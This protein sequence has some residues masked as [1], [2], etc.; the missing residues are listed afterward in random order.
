[1]KVLAIGAHPDDVELGCFATLAKLAKE[2]HEIHILVCT[3]GEAG[4]VDAEAK[5]SRIEEARQSAELLNAKIYFGNLPDTKLSDG[6][7]TIKLIEKYVK[8]INPEIL[9]F[10]HRNDIHQDHRHLASAVVSATRFTPHEV[11]M[12]ESPSTSKSFIPSVYF[13]V[14]DTFDIKIMAVKIHQSQGKKSYMADRAIRGLAE[15]RAFEIG[16]NDRLVEG[17][18]PLR[19]LHK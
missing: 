17:F 14:T 15:F 5:L 19:V 7:D 1:M 4:M 3:N 2:G 11:Y 16:L 8:E 18:E 9:F 6:I 13:D 12:Y 10:N